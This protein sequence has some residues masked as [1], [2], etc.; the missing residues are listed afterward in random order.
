MADMQWKEA[1]VQVLT[2]QAD[3]V[4]YTDIAEMIVQ[5]GLKKKG[6]P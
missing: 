3:P 1:I 5:Q 2:G 6:S 4:H